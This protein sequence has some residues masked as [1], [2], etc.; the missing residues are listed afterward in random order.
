MNQLLF[1]NLDKWKEKKDIKT[2]YKLTHWRDHNYESCNLQNSSF[3][4]SYKYKLK[5]C[6]TIADQYECVDPNKQFKS[7][8]IDIGLDEWQTSG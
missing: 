3:A 5:Y 2:N 8:L 6:N 1:F 4:K 7:C